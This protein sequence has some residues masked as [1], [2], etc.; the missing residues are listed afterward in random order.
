MSVATDM[1]AA[2]QV[3]DVEVAAIVR[4]YGQSYK[5]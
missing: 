1:L 3:T 4:D 5:V 2:R